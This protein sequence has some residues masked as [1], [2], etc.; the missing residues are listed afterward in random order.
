[1]SKIRTLLADKTNS[2]HTS[3]CP[4]NLSERAPDTHRI[5]DLGPGCSTAY[6]AF[7]SAATVRFQPGAY[8]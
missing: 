8:I 3:P 1:M 2:F 6:P 7:C 5:G 4:F